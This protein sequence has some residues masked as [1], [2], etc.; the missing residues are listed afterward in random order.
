M[1]LSRMN[2]WTHA[3]PLK[4]YTRALNPSSGKYIFFHT[5][6]S[7]EVSLTEHDALQDI[8]SYLNAVFGN[9][10]RLTLFK[11]QHEFRYA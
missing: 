5:Q 8:S 4:S 3:S 2:S 11:L 7:E 9:S 1:R 6:Q 10:E